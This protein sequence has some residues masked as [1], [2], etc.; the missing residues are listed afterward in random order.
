MK[1]INFKF[2]IR[3]AI[4]SIKIT[5][6][7]VTGLKWN[8]SEYKTVRSIEYWVQL[9]A[10]KLWANIKT[11]TGENE[12]AQEIAVRRSEKPKVGGTLHYRERKIECGFTGIIFKE[13]NWNAS[14]RGRQDWQL[15]VIVF[16]CPM[17][18]FTRGLSR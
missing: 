6:C 15:I 16:Q 5:I 17:L 12:W 2:K 14:P 8:K 10:K 4:K 13:P 7:V 11:N 18:H 1:R 3:A 9:W